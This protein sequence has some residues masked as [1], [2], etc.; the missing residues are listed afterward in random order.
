MAKGFRSLDQQL[1]WP[2]PPDKMGDIVQISYGYRTNWVLVAEFEMAKQA[3][4][5]TVD[6]P[7]SHRAHD[8]RELIDY[9]N[10]RAV[11]GSPIAVAYEIE[12]SRYLDEL[13]TGV[14]GLID[15]PLHHFLFGG[16]NLC[17]EIIASEFPTIHTTPPKG[18]G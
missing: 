4:W 13:K 1:G 3:V 6:D 10:Q 12:T 7:I 8:E 15:T 2:F 5:I 18:I 9:W 16:Q 17:L 11:E 14:S